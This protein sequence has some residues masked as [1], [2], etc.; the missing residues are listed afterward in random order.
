MG[1]LVWLASYPKSGNTWTRSFLHNL[2]DGDGKGRD[3]NALGELAVWDLDARWYK[4]LLPAPIEKCTSEQVAAV[5]PQ[6]MRNIMNAAPGQIFVKTHNAMMMDRG[7]PLIEPAVTRG[8]VYLVR[9]P[10][11]VVLSYASHMGKSIDETIRIMGL[12]R[13]QGGNSA[14]ASYQVIGS[15]SENVASWTTRPKNMVHVMRYEDLHENPRRC[16][17]KLA[18]YLHIP[19]GHAQLAKAADACSFDNLR[20]Q[21]EKSGYY[22]K[23][24]VAERFFRK[25]TAGQWR[26]ALTKDQITAIVSQ[27]RSQMERFDY[28]PEGF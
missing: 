28:V 22:E 13:A 4:G 11:D 14:L 20:K 10:L 5:R 23:P 1:G 19:C 8:A 7:A 26:D 17:G 15:W 9:N 18:E 21:E 24:A 16:F 27:H 25:G 3:I 6:A 12:S 2:L